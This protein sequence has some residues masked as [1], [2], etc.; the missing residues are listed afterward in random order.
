MSDFVYMSRTHLKWNCHQMCKTHRLV[1]VLWPTVSVH[2][3]HPVQP[4]WRGPHGIRTPSLVEDLLRCTRS[5]KLDEAWLWSVI[6]MNGKGTNIGKSKEISASWVSWLKFCNLLWPVSITFSS[7]FNHIT[8]GRTAKWS[9]PRQSYRI[10]CGVL[11][12]WLRHSRWRIYAVR[13]NLGQWKRISVKLCF[14]WKVLGFT[15][16]NKSDVFTRL[17]NSLRLEQSGFY[18]DGCSVTQTQKWRLRSR[19]R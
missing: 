10:I 18:V 16:I 19:V 9:I 2:W 13:D 6:L 3:A 7:F 4:R 8:G 14:I 5:R 17:Q 11:D 15:S 1:F 12:R